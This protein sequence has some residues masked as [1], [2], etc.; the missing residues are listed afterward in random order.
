MRFFQG[1]RIKMY[2]DTD[3]QA[4]LNF[5]RDSGWNC[6]TSGEYI[7]VTTQRGN[8]IDRVKLA[9]VL[10]DARRKIKTPREKLAKELGVAECTIWS[11]EVARTIPKGDMLKTYCG[12]LGLDYEG[13]L[14]DCTKEI[15]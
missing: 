3:V 8:N 11:W 1:E 4:Y 13:V 10:K 6:K 2:P 15:I 7:I 9:Q 14:E 5:I 12:V